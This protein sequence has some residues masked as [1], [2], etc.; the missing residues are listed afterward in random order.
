MEQL[1]LHKLVNLKKRFDKYDCEISKEIVAVIDKHLALER[2]KS[3]LKDEERRGEYQCKT[4][5][6][7]ICNKTMLR[8]SIYKHMKTV[9]SDE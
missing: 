6:C 1:N 7:E 3:R 4:V 8:Q 2:E 9:H 5:I